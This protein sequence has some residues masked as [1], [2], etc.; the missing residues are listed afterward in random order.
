MTNLRV[1][2]VLFSLIVCMAFPNLTEAQSRKRLRE[3]EETKENQEAE[4]QAAEDAGRERHLDIQ[5]KQTRKEMRRYRKLSK[6][7][8]NNRKPLF[9]RRRGK[10]KRRK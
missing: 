2:A 9:N 5:S 7:Y 3:L 1:N 4:A 6:Q 8:N 10:R